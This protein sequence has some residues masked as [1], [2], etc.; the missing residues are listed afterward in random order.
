MARTRPKSINS[1][2]LVIQKQINNDWGVVTDWDVNSW[3]QSFEVPYEGVDLDII[4]F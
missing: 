2:D 1:G 3:A 4:A